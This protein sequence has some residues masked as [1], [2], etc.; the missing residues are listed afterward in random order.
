[1]IILPTSW[2]FKSDRYRRLVRLKT[3]QDES[4][5]HSV[6]QCIFA[7]Y[8]KMKH[9]EDKKVYL[10]KFKSSLVN[11][12]DSYE[13]LLRKNRVSNLLEK[14]SKD[15]EINIYLF[16][17]LKDDTIIKDRFIHSINSPIIMIE[18]CDYYYPLGIQ[19][20]RG[21]HLLLFSNYDTEV[22]RCIESF[23]KSR[24]SDTYKEN[25]VSKIVIDSS[26]LLKYNVEKLFKA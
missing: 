24:I 19:D 9:I 3:I 5:I 22:K 23:D 8:R 25:E 18:K 7:K 1:M 21:I 14:I 20:R 26:F 13:V 16:R 10:S 11:F 17:C 15:F 4:L 12:D 2:L 6:M